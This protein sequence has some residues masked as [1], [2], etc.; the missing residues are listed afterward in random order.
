MNKQSLQAYLDLVQ[1]LLGCPQ[2]EEWIVLRQH[3]ELVNLG[4]VEVMEQVANYLAMEGK[5]KPAKYLHNWASQLHHILIDSNATA[6][7]KDDRID[8]YSELIESLLKCPEGLE[9]QI[10]AAHQD[11]ID[12][13]LIQIMKEVADRLIPDDPETA[14]YL[15]NMA[16]DL[17]R[18]WLK[19]HEFMPTFKQEIAPD[20]WLDEYEQTSA[21]EPA[22]TDHPHLETSIPQSKLVPTV[23]D[24]PPTFTNKAIARLL[25]QIVESLSK[26][27]ITIAARQQIQNP[28]WYMEV[29]EKAAAA[30]WILTTNEVEQL[31]GVKPHCDRD[32]RQFH[33]GSWIF[34][35]TG[36]VGAQM[37]WKVKKV[38]EE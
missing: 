24:S 20:P 31:I 9:Q 37:A 18:T 4:L 13:N 36:K 7:D 26:L 22:I 38:G 11:L 5:T 35:K 25:T 21:S 10:L 16:A 32:D 30:E 17:D 15:Q 8:A 23:S 6:G 2:G 29:L 34:V 12:P 14:E 28:L 27:E 33:R 3:G 19:H 1:K